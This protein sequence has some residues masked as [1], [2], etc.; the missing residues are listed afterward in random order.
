VP[1][2]DALDLEVAAGLGC[3]FATAY[4]AVVARGQVRGGDWFAVHGCGG[5]GLSAVMIAIA[6]G[7]RVVAIDPSATARERAV[8]L[9]ARRSATSRA[10]SPA[11]SRRAAAHPPPSPA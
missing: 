2:P 3:R 10:M 4:R 7:A 11:A 1:L 8:G 5:L 6:E 9:Q